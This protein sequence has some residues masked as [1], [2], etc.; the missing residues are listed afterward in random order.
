MKM[1]RAS[2]AATAGGGAPSQIITKGGTHKGASS[3][4]QRNE[5][6]SRT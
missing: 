4:A 3:D 6:L 1:N 5:A 2:M